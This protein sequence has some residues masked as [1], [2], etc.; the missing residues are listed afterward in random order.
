MT[1]PTNSDDLDSIANSSSEALRMAREVL[2]GIEKSRDEQPALLAAARNA[3][4][5][6]R[7]ATIE[8]QPW[9][10][11]LQII[12]TQTLDGEINGMAAFPGLEAKEIWG[13]RLLF[14]LIG[15]TDN[16]GEIND[17]LN[18]YFTLLN[19]DTA[20]LFIVMSAALVTC[21]DTVIPMLLKDIEDHGSN[22]GARVYLA[23]AAR[24]SWE[25]NINALRQTP[26]YEAD[27]DE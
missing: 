7:E 27:G 12:P 1:Y 8:E 10:D 17:V 24:K 21:A 9:L 18:R 19:G 22:Y 14:D 11:N 23:D 13:S 25:L 5:A 20:H 15:C 2:A 3:A 4:D 26:N 16:D 6:A